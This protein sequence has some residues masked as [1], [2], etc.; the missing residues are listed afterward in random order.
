MRVP[1]FI[2]SLAEEPL[3]VDAGGS[4]AEWSQW[5]NRW[6]VSL[7]ERTLKA[8]AHR[9]PHLLVQLM[10]HC[11]TLRSESSDRDWDRLSR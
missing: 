9:R 8:L 6:E 10:G 5:A 4:I 3:N 1:I 11:A 2:P 7:N